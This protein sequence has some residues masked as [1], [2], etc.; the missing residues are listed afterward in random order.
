MDRISEALSKFIP[1]ERI[2]E[3][4]PMRK[5]TSFRTGGDADRLILIDT[6]EELAGVLSFL[7]GED[8]PFFILGNGTNLLVSD[9]GYRGSIIELS[10]EFKNI[11]IS[12][13]EILSG[14]GSLLVNIAET[15]LK[16]G[17]TGFE[18]ASG[19]PGTVGGAIVMN[20]GAYGG[21]MKDIVT[22]VDV[23]TPEGEFKRL[24]NEELS[25]GY[26]RSIIREASYIVLE[27]EFKLRSGDREEIRLKMEELKEKRNEKQPL[28]FPSAGSTFKRPEGNFAG[29]L[30]MDAGLKGL[31]KGGAQVSEK[32]CGFIIN[33]GD[34]TSDDI[35]SLI[36]TVKER[37]YEDSGV[38]LE[39]EILMIGE[40]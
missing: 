29:K 28:N 39:P 6:R 19:I 4:E 34:A 22:F 10:S 2:L 14:A 5:H 37:V 18:F 26:R 9:R 8:L 25:F 36:N 3:K 13:E 38:M 27:A 17:L 12:G 30:I 40:F 33:T 21:E 20:A 1:P 35:I 24:K 7:R 11:S 16:E 31:R 32:H 23:L 15:A